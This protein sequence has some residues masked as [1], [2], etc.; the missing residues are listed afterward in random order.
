MN[1]SAVHFPFL[2][3]HLHAV[4]L[5]ISHHKLFDTLFSYKST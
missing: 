1:K 5:V 4:V 2:P 3:I